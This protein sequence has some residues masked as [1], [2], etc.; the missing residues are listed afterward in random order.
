MLTN[1]YEK[2]SS[3]GASAEKLADI[4]LKEYYGETGIT[5]PINPFQM[6]TDLGIPFVLRPFKKYE[7]VYIPSSGQDDIPIIG[8]NLKRP[9]VRQRFTAA[10]ELCHHLKDVHRGFVC[11]ANPQSEIECYAEA[12]ASELLMPNEEFEKQAALQEKNG[13]IDFDGVLAIADYFGVSFQAC[14]YK[15][16]YK[17]HRIEGDT[18]PRSLK[19]RSNK[20]KPQIK[21]NENGWY[22]TIL[23]EQLINAIGENFK[24]KPTANTCQRFKAEYIFYD[25]RMEGV[26][27]DEETVGDIVSDL[28]IRKQDSPFCMEE[29]Q[30]IIEV[31]GLTLA[32]DY[33]FNT[34]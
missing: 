18:S 1:N 4:F 19:S 27:I 2:L 34:P 5:F 30:N 20:Y 6:L 22:Y 31:A 29:N 10:H 12:F 32:Y 25:S 16:A 24:L 13:Y 33:A 3:E 14:L 15:I 9:I 11:T 8:I 23:Y 17:L 26:D 28:R 21:R 7:G